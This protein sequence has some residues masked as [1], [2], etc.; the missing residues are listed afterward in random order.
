MSKSSERTLAVLLLDNCAPARV[1]DQD[2]LMQAQAV[3]RAL[4]ALGYSCERVYLSPSVVDAMARLQQ[5][6]PAPCPEGWPVAQEKAA[7]ASVKAHE[8]KLGEHT[9]GSIWSTPRM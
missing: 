7:L 1:D 2:A 4:A 6:A 8:N 5:L 3:E 9:Y